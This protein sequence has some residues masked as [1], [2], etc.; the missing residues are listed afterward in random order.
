MK[1]SCIYITKSM[2]WSSSNLWWF[3]PFGDFVT[4]IPSVSLSLSLWL[5]RDVLLDAKT[6]C[7]V[8]FNYNFNVWMPPYCPQLG[9][10]YEIALTL[11]WF[12]ISVTNSSTKQILAPRISSTGLNHQSS[13]SDLDSVEICWD[14]P[15]LCDYW[16]TPGQ[17]VYKQRVSYVGHSWILGV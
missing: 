11:W 2:K 12:R 16:S 8:S 5:F 10:F 9:N 14:G 17:H 13:A 3:Y 1:S 15:W 6:W 4:F 7:C